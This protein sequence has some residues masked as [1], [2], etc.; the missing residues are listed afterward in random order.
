MSFKDG[1]WHFLNLVL[2]TSLSLFL[3][4]SATS[5]SVY[6]QENQSFGNQTLFES[7]ELTDKETIRF[8]RSEQV[9]MNGSEISN[10]EESTEESLVSQVIPT[11]NRSITGPYVPSA[12]S[13]D[14]NNALS[15]GLETNMT[16]PRSASNALTSA[17]GDNSGTAGL[18][19]E[20]PVGDLEANMTEPSPPPTTSFKTS[21]LVK[22]LSFEAHP[23]T[24]VMENQSN[25][26]AEPSVAAY[27]NTIF[28]TGNSFVARSFDGGANWEN[29]DPTKDFASFCCDQRVVFDPS[30]KIYIWYRQGNQGPPELE[31]PNENIVKF[32]VSKD[33]ISWTM[34]SISA[35]SLSKS[36]SSYF[37][38]YPNVAT[39]DNNLYITTN[40]FTPGFTTSGSLIIKI[41]LD[42]LVKPSNVRYSMFFEDGALTFTPVQGAS[43]K[44]YWASHLT[45]DKIKIYEWDDTIDSQGIKTYVRS[46][47]PWFVLAQASGQCSRITSFSTT[48]LEEGNWCERSDSRITSGWKQDNTIGFVWNANGGS[49]STLG[50]TFPF[51][52]VNSASFNISENLTYSDRPYLWNKFF[53]LQY[54]STAPSLDGQVGLI[55]FY[56]KN[57]N[58][59]SLIFGVLNA[60]NDIKPWDSIFLINSTSSP[61][62]QD[63][64]TN[65]GMLDPG[66]PYPSLRSFNYV[67]GD[68]ITIMPDYE[69]S[70]RWVA[71]GYI[72]DEGGEHAKPYYFILTSK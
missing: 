11:T 41:P 25:L 48:H 49:L 10:L 60:R 70:S 51:P 1:S 8:E 26:I 28:Y 33:T 54:A 3:S 64:C 47:P 43:D 16:E 13:A 4:F 53:P 42:D 72:V 59:P 56:G 23:V 68:Y 61:K 15:S 58:E 71:A 55:A 38:D 50:A 67:W 39:A 45:N 29:L 57:I 6:S 62:I 7:G 22:N 20:F 40:A 21:G 31:D 5:V 66:C 27:N 18:E 65:Q 37:L 44:M 12:P 63:V 52:Y 35:Q 19:T 30:H 24:S 69:Q 46:I 14:S 36:L 2:L 17:T 9:T 32:G 34:F